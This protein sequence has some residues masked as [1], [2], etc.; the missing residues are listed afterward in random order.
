M[1]SS[2]SLSAAFEASEAFWDIPAFASAAAELPLEAPASSMA[3]ETLLVTDS[4]LGD[5]S[6]FD[7]LSLVSEGREGMTWLFDNWQLERRRLYETE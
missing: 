2:Y 1:F 3:E 4:K 7:G 5:V 6:L